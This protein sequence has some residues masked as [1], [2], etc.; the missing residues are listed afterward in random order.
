MMPDSPDS[1]D[2]PEPPAPNAAVGSHRDSAG[3]APP[4]DFG[5]NFP[6]TW[7]GL[8]LSHQ[9]WLIYVLPLAVFMVGTSLEPKPPKQAPAE[10]AEAERGWFDLGIEYRH[11]PIVYTAKI[12]AVVAVMLFVLPGYREFPLRVG[13]FAVL[14]GAVGG[15]LWIVLCRLELEQRILPAV[16]LGGLVDMGRRS[17]FDPLEQLAA[18]TAWAYGFLAIRFFGLVIVVPVIEEFFLRGFLMRFTVAPDWWRV[19][20]GTVTRT[21][22]VVGTAVPMLM[23]PGELVAAAA[24]F[25]LISWLMVRT[26]N[27][28]D[29][30]AAHAITNLILGVYVVGW[31]RW[32]LM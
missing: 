24:W 5:A 30:V 13:L 23:H 27:I 22:L 17:G 3:H 32:E 25:S 19:P 10:A 15:V 12:A 20:F 9:P 28:W 7:R 2:R 4:H 16:G 8:L 14:V 1:A 18:T 26:R 11:Y 29:C 6:D 21:A 31:G